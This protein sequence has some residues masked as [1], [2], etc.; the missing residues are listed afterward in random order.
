MPRGTMQIRKWLLAVWFDVWIRSAR[1]WFVWQSCGMSCGTRVSRRHP[2]CTL[3]N[4]TSKECSLF[5]SH[6]IR[7]WRLVLRLSKS[8]LSARFLPTSLWCNQNCVHR[9]RTFGF[10]V[11]TV[12]AVRPLVE[13]FKDHPACENL[14]PAV[15]HNLTR[16][17]GEKETVVVV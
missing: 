9:Y 6:C 17:N 14:A 4:G 7:W 2:D 12:C 15:S 13:L 5:W 3:V 10:S 16:S 11:V 8:L 1:S